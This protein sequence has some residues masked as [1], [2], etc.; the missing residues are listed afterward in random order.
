MDENDQGISGVV[1]A[2]SGMS[3]PVTVDVLGHQL[4]VACYGSHNVRMY[5]LNGN[6]QFNYGGS[7][8]M[9]KAYGSHIDQWGRSIVSDRDNNRII[10]LSADGNH[11]KDLLQGFTSGPIGLKVMDNFI[12]VA[13]YSPAIK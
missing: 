5:D 1:L 9:N 4:I 2:S 6:L 10:V 8:V 12:Y 3:M 13:S 11:I 7:G